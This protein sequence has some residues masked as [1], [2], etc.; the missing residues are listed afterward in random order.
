MT[1]EEDQYELK[2]DGE[3]AASLSYLDHE[4]D[5]KTLSGKELPSQQ[6]K[7]GNKVG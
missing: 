3:S 1:M 2:K 7:K 6:K 4:D 5:S